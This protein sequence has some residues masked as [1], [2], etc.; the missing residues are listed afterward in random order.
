MSE[1]SYRVAKEARADLGRRGGGPASR[2]D[3]VTRLVNAAVYRYGHSPGVSAPPQSVGQSENREEAAVGERDVASVMTTTV[4]TVRP[5]TPFKDVVALMAEHDVS[6]LPVV[7]GANRPI[8]VV[9]EADVLTKQE[10]RGGS[11]RIPSHDRAGLE[12][13]IRSL[14]LVA[15]ELMTSPIRTIAVDVPL[16]AAA[17]QLAKAGVRRL[18]VVDEHGS[19]VGVLSRRDLMR[20]YLRSDD[21]I[22]AE[23]EDL[24][25]SSVMGAGPGT[26]KVAV[27]GGVTTVDGVLQRRRQ[28]DSVSRLVP[29]VTGV[30]AVRN[31]L[32][33]MVDDLLSPP[34]TSFST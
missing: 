25:A 5:Q 24:L 31:N 32:R 14:A 6:A 10:F 21:E 33:W 15:G 28:V 8:G 27:R 23:V 17:R 18:L 30:V 22:R 1:E 9:S 26:V 19:L 4:I 34:W 11:D 13:W 3:A 7:D 12:R 2:E 20:V 29:T 16:T